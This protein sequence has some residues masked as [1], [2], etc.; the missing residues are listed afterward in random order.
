MRYSTLNNFASLWFAFLIV[1][2]K[3]LVIVNPTAAYMVGSKN[4]TNSMNSVSK[5]P[6]PTLVNTGL[7]S[8]TYKQPIGY[9][10]LAGSSRVP[11]STES[12]NLKL[13]EASKLSLTSKRVTNGDTPFEF[14]MPLGEMGDRNNMS[15]QLSSSTFEATI[16]PNKIDTKRM[17]INYNNASGIFGPGSPEKLKNRT[18]AASNIHTVDTVYALTGAQHPHNMT[19]YPLQYNGKIYQVEYNIT[20]NN[21][22]IAL[23]I[24]RGGT[25]L[26]ANLSSRAKGSLSMQLP[27]FMTNHEAPGTNHSSEFVVFKDTQYAHFDQ[28]TKSRNA[29]YITIDFDKE[30]K[31]IAVVPLHASPELDARTVIGYAFCIPILF[32]IMWLKNKGRLGRFKY[33]KD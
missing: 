2:L 12:A 26:Q 31:R 25:T 21:K 23:A 14:P 15:S 4:E 6:F 3:T 22:L 33:S 19:T 9:S 5:L 30:T 1:L 18:S 8:E 29:T 28:W 16:V 32:A 11:F 7:Q 17:N 24:E 10:Y 27:K 13:E 20:G